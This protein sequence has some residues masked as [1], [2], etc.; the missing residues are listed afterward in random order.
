MLRKTSTMT[1]SPKKN[2]NIV[3]GRNQGKH[4]AT[5]QDQSNDY[6][7]TSPGTSG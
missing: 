5:D 3:S 2:Q 4:L 1:R 7:Y 6:G